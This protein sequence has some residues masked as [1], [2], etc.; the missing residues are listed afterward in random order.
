MTLFVVSLY[1]TCSLAQAKNMGKIK[2]RSQDM[3]NLMQAN[4]EEAEMTKRLYEPKKKVKGG[5]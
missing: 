3:A 5:N 4:K 1:Q 2:M